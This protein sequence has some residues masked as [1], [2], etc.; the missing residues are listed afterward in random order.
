MSWVECTWDNATLTALDWAHTSA[1]AD[2]DGDA[3][4]ASPAPR[5]G[6]EAE[7]PL[8]AGTL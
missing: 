2:A 5:V 8:S 1:I 6:D 7:A 3:C 4:V